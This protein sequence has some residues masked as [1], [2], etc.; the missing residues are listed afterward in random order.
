MKF[1][2]VAICDLRSYNTPEAASSVEAVHNAALVILPKNCDEQT[3]AALAKI[4]MKNVAST[5]YADADTTLL[6]FNGETVLSDNNL[7]D[8][9]SICIINGTAVILP[10]SENK[11]VS[12]IVNGKAVCDKGSRNG[13]Q[14]NLLCVNG[15]VDTIDLSGVEFLPDGA[16]LPAE[17]FLGD[18]KNRYY[19]KL[20]FVQAVPAEA[21]GEIMANLVVAHPSVQK[22]ALSLSAG[23]VVYSNT[24]GAILFKKDLPE[25]RVT[26][27]LLENVPGKL[28]LMDIA[29]LYIDKDVTAEL[30]LE[31]VCLISDIAQL[32][33]T[34]ETFDV[35][36]LLAHDVA[37]IR[38]R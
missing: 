34:K 22:S 6:T 10:L 13:G 12:L 18:G 16:I 4:D 27:T 31:K 8:G 9:D 11:Q 30:L 33:A 24:D 26:K 38:R 20:V 1:Q 5:V 7:P 25:F 36:Q 17:R 29:K 19:G 35:V 15:K 21:H 3:R 28:V 2:N 23:E 14:I 37:K 32:R